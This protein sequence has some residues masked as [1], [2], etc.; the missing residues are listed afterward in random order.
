M[1]EWSIEKIERLRADLKYERSLSTRLGNKLNAEKEKES[2]LAQAEQ[3]IKELEEKYHD[4]LFQVE[5]KFPGESRHDT[6]KRFIF[7]WEHRSAPTA[8]KAF[9]SEGE[10]E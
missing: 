7:N 8:S 2:R 6:A 3:R 1:P 5:S 4:L 10:G 9:S